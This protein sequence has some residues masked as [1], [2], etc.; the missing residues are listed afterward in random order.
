MGGLV[1]RLVD[2]WKDGVTYLPD[3]ERSQKNTLDAPSLAECRGKEDLDWKRV[4][5]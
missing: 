2:S 3:V 1:R 5:F 4:I